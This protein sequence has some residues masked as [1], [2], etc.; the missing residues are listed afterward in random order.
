[1]QTYTHALRRD[2]SQEGPRQDALSQQHAAQRVEGGPIYQVRPQTHQQDVRMPAR[3]TSGEGSQLNYGLSQG[4]D[5]HGDGLA[6]A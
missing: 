5:P 6:N 1:M 3:D 4:A 2:L